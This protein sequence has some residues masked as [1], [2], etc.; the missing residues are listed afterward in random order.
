[1]ESGFA[2]LDGVKSIPLQGLNERIVPES[3]P[4]GDLSK[5]IGLRQDRLGEL[6][7][8]PGERLLENS[9]IFSSIRGL[10]PF[11]EYLIIQTE[12]TLVRLRLSELFSDFPQTI[13]ELFPDNYTPTGTGAAINPEN[14]SYALINYELVSGSDAAAT[15]AATW[16]LVPFNTEEADSA[17]RVVVTAGTIT[18]SAGVYPA[19][20][21]IDGEVCVHAPNSLAANANSSQRAALRFKQVS[22]GTIVANGTT[23]RETTSNSAGEGRPTGTAKIRGRFSIAAATDFQLQ[24]YTTQ[25]TFFGKAL[26]TGEPE[27]YA[28]LEILVEE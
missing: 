26:T 17:N 1:M 16:N 19:F 2:D 8:Y 27:V 14:M 20:V 6:V 13:P 22:G 24:L 28:Q 21:R 4:I 18:I 15:V 23:F 7:R 11:G 25:G 12:R 5:L 9:A 10:F 3:I